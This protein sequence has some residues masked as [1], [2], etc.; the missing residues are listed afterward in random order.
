MTELE[1]MNNKAMYHTVLHKSNR[2][3]QPLHYII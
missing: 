3:S 2:L 1:R